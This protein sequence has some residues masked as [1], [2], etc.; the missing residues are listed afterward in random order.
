[1]YFNAVKYSPATNKGIYFSFGSSLVL[2]GRCETKT[3]LKWAGLCA[4]SQGE[5]LLRLKPEKYGFLI[6]CNLQLKQ[7]W[8][9][10]YG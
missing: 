2:L 8:E 10:H 7:Q 4:V 1:M 5:F 6:G 3:E 9:K